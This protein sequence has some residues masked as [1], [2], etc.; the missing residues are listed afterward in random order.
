MSNMVNISVN[1]LQKIS[2][3]QYGRRKGIDMHLASQTWLADRIWHSLHIQLQCTDH[4]PI[5]EQLNASQIVMSKSPVP[6]G[7]V[8]SNS[9]RR[10]HLF[11]H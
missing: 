8:K 6:E 2:R 5:Q 1:K 7:Q 10:Q 4:I 9:H 11:S 3:S